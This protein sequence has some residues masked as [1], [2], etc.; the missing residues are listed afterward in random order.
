ML[1]SWRRP[2]AAI[3]ALLASVLGLTACD[4]PTNY[5][6]LGDSYT[7]GPLIPVQRDDPGGCLRSTNNYPSVAARSLTVNEHRDPSCSGG[8]TKDM[9]APQD[10]EFGPNPP[11][12]DSLD[13]NTTLVTLGI[14]GNDLGFT[15][16]A[17]TC[18]E[19][20]VDDPTGAPC[21]AFFTSGGQDQIAQR[22]SATA[23]LVA[24]VI[25]GIRQRSPRAKIFVVGYPA[26]LPETVTLASWAQCYPVLPVA[27]GDIGWLRE[28]V[29][30]A[31]NRMLRAEAGAHGAVFV[32]TYKPSI[33]HDAC[34]PPLIRWVEPLVPADGA[35]P[36]HPNIRGMAG[37]AQ[38]VLAA[39]RANGVPTH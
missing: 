4:A 27:L 35:A 6:S 28:D 8:Q 17:T 26:I 34:Q 13:A 22:I 21:K 14:G 20:S 3:G 15:D 36:V 11:Q 18:G 38:A 33:G 16:I 39:M 19:K 7:S 31:L 1:Q 10:V 30:K 37:S 12:F 29:E 25:D 23:P 32:N 24:N 5:V 9:T 2:T